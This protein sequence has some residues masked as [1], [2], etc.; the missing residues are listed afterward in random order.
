MS[1]V[2]Q[3][4]VLN[5]MKANNQ[6]ADRAEH[7]SNIMFEAPRPYVQYISD[8]VALRYLYG[9]LELREAGVLE[10]DESGRFFVKAGI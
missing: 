7:A 4:R 6:N 10:E 3:N 1:K 8:D 5:Y 2:I 9:V